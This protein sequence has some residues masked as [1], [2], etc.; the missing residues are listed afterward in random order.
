MLT[1]T[2]VNYNLYLVDSDGDLLAD[3]NGGGFASKLVL[4]QSGKVT[5]E[6]VDS[7]GQT[8]Y[9]AYD[10]IPI[11]DEFVE[12]HPDFSYRGAKA[13]LAL[14]GYNGLFGYR[15]NPS[16]SNELWILPRI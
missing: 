11:L 13:I 12:R 4:D 8:I 9:G 1:Q 3:K 7:N 5:C 6:M 10:M 2:N 14:T 15:T 16:R